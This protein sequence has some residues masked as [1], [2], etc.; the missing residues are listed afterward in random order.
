MVKE[1]VIS[2]NNA[3]FSYDSVSVLTDV[4]LKVYEHDF[5]F[6]I[7]PNAGGKTTLLKLILGL[8][9]PDT[10]SI[11]VFGLPPEKAS[12]RIG[13]MPQH[14]TM[15]LRFPVDVMDVV[16]MGRLRTNRIG[17]YAGA[18]RASARAALKRLDVYD[19]RKRPF[20]A[21]SGGQ[22]QRVL[23]AR[24]LVS[25]PDLLLLDEPTANVDAVAETELYDFLHQLSR[26]I[27]V[28][29]VTH[30]VGFVSRYANSVACVNGTVGLHPTAEIN[31]TMIQELYGAQ[32]RMVQHGH[33]LSGNHSHD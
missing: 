29:L 31:G 21:L 28:V 3:S 19:V 6:L 9:Q 24:A 4:T 20:S 10:G 30:D 2:V 27:T 16:L 1:P 11:T 26:E 7:G 5:L 32:M 33:H 17:F 18:D 23:I 12:P 25:E 14:V 8:L 15:D 13:Y 22:R